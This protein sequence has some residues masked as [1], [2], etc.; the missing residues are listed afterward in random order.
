[1]K[2]EIWIALWL[3]F[4]TSIIYWDMNRWEDKEPLSDCH[5]AKIIIYHDKP[6]CMECKMYCE[7]V[8]GQREE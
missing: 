8:D 4:A 7:L 5:N 6:M 2:L 1:M 3:I